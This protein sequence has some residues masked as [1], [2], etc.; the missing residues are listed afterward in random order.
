MKRSIYLFRNPW[1]LDL[2]GCL[3]ICQLDDLSYT[4][5]WFICDFSGKGPIIYSRSMSIY[6]SFYSQE[7]LDCMKYDMDCTFGLV[8]NSVSEQLP[9][10]YLA[11][12]V[13]RRRIIEQIC[14]AYDYHPIHIDSYF[15]PWPSQTVQSFLP[16]SSIFENLT[17]PVIG[18]GRAQFK[19]INIQTSQS[20]ISSHKKETSHT[21]GKPRNRSTRKTKNSKQEAKA[22]NASE[23]SS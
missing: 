17:F 11:W 21:R 8:Y 14:I 18:K 13:D 2:I 9:F 7:L 5:Y 4:G 20:H 10:G 1:F 22:G 19:Q 6:N 3:R 23:T 15:L 12:N 16:H